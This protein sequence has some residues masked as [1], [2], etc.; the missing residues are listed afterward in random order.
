MD[1]GMVIV[2]MSKFL[3]LDFIT[4]RKIQ[5]AQTTTSP[6]QRARYNEPELA[7]QMVQDLQNAVKMRHAWSKTV[8]KLGENVIAF[9]KPI[10]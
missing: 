2:K 3:Q 1:N 10:L 6:I 9:R 5:L 8:E 4:N 7:A